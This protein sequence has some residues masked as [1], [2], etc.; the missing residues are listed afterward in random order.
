VRYIVRVEYAQINNCCSL[1]FGVE[2][3]ELSKLSGA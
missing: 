2:A 1:M 3:M